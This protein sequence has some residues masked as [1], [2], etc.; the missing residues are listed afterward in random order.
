MTGLLN[1]RGLEAFWRNVQ[2]DE[3]FVLVVFDIDN[4]KSINDTFGHDKGDEVI[5]YM[6]R[7]IHNGI[8]SSDVGARFG[9][10]ELWST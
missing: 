8:R 2:H 7:Q 6:A 5:R 1:R 3:L 9:G 10:E 4:F